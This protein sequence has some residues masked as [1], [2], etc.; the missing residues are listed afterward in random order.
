MKIKRKISGEVQLIIQAAIPK[1]AIST[2]NGYI[3]LNAV[4]KVLETE[5]AEIEDTI[6]VIT[7]S[8]LD[9]AVEGERVTF[10]EPQNA[11]ILKTVFPLLAEN[12]LTGITALQVNDVKNIQMTYK[13]RIILKLGE[14]SSV[15][16]KMDF[17]VAALHRNEE[18][19]ES[20]RGTIDFTIDKKAFL[21]PE[22]ETKKEEQE[23]E[24]KKT[25]EIV[26]TTKT[27]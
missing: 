27:A 9:T 20:F 19:M 23:T 24:D 22:E 17:V 14:L 16:D 6:I 25:E 4:G 12:N 1:A 10:L 13:N 2:E 8:T 11:E 5:V 18:K 21:H 26:E 15:P 3:L 7:D